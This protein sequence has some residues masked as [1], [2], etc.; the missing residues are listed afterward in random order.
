MA[1]KKGKAKKAKKAKAPRRGG[2][3][4]M[5]GGAWWNTVWD[6]V[7]SV[8]KFVKDNSLVSKGLDAAGLGKYAGFARQVGLGKGKGKAM[9]GRGLSVNI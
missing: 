4:D 8:G 6:G 7:K 2:S 3:A 1:P 9:R 5:H